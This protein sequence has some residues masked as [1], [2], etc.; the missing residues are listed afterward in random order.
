MKKKLLILAYEYYPTE[1]ANTRIIRHTCELLTDRFE[2]DLVTVETGHGMKTSAEPSPES[3]YI[4]RVPAYSFHREKC[5]GKMTAPVLARMF[6][7]KTRGRLDH[8]DTRMLERL[9]EREIRKAVNV[10]DYDAVITF[11]APVLAHGCASRMIRGTKTRWLAVCLDPYFSHRIF[12]PEGLEERKRREEKYMEPAEKV[13]VA[14]PT[15]RDYLRAGVAFA[16][17]IIPVEMPGIVVRG[18][19]GHATCFG[20]AIRCGFFGSMYREIR[21]PRTAIA[22]FNEVAKDPEIEAAFAGMPAD[23][24]AEELFPAGSRV[25]YLGVLSGDDLKRRYGETDVLINIG[26][27]VDNQMPSKIFE[28]ISTGKPIINIYKSPECPTLK[29]LTKYPLALN[30]G[31]EALKDHLPEKAAEVCAFCRESRGKS[32]PAEEITK[33]F[34]ANTFEAFADTIAKWVNGPGM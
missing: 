1:N 22:L 29:Y 16:N 6:Y 3:F 21:D 10:K 27:S 13:M 30:I 2:M 4:I 12:G 17:K 32:V 15:D 18:E 19:T 9:Y 24:S 33:T 23:L 28:Y 26:N 14:Y 8:D 7:E 20:P 5:T 34:A 31:E 25:Q 11:S